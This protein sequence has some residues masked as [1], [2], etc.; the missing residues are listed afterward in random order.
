MLVNNMLTVI[1][2]H[3]SCAFNLKWKLEGMSY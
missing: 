3:A 1:Y 2:L